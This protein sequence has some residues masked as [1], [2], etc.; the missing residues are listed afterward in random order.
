MVLPLLLVLYGLVELYMYKYYRIC[1]YPCELGSISLLVYYYIYSNYSC[2][3]FIIINSTSTYLSILR[4]ASMVNPSSWPTN[5]RDTVR[6]TSRRCGTVIHGI[7]IY[8]FIILMLSETLL[9]M[10][11][12]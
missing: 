8:Y 9:F 2:I 7:Y 12:F 4:A 11:L 6:E 3:I 1:S 5:L 10:V